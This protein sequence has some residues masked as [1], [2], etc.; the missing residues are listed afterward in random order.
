[1][2]PA[3]APALVSVLIP[4]VMDYDWD[5]LAEESLLPHALGHGTYHSNRKLTRTDDF[6]LSC[7]FWLCTLPI[8]NELPA[9]ISQVAKSPSLS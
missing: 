4:S 5:I 6:L 8:V 3:S 9:S 2:A 7:P 1:M